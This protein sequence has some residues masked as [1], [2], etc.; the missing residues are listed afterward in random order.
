MTLIVSTFFITFFVMGMGA[1]IAD[2]SHSP[3]LTP[4]A[5]K[6]L[7]GSTAELQFVLWAHTS[8]LTDKQHAH[9]LRTIDRCMAGV[10]IG[11]WQYH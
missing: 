3:D 7:C 9:G 11:S 6:L 8:L 1:F 2:C 5:P 10:P 4:A